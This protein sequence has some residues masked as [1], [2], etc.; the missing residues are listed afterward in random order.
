ME[1]KGYD[2]SSNH[3]NVGAGH[4]LPMSSLEQSSWNARVVMDKPQ[5]F[6]L[7]FVFASMLIGHVFALQ[8]WKVA[9]DIEVSIHV[10]DTKGLRGFEG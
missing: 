9:R 8:L 2:L 1:V 10:G 6:R 4:H 3:M 7:L 5:I